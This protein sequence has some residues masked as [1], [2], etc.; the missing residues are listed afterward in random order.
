MLRCFTRRA[1]V[2]T[3]ATVAAVLG[4]AVA[5]IPAPALAGNV[6][7]NLTAT[8]GYADLDSTYQITNAIPIEGRLGLTFYR[9]ICV[10]G[11]YGKLF[12]DSALDP[13]RDFPAD[14]IGADVLL[15]ILP[16]ATFNPFVL[17]G[18]TQLSVD[19][20]SSNV[21]MNGFEFGGGIKIALMRQQ[22]TRLDMRLEARDVVVKNKSPFLPDGESTHNLF[23]TGAIELSFFGQEVDSDRDGVDNNHDDC[24]NTPRW[25]TVD[26]RGCPIDTD[27]D[28]VYDGIDQCPNTPHHA[29]VDD[30]G[31]PSDTDGDGV[32]D[33]IDRCPNTKQ[34]VKVD[35]TG[36]PLDSDGDGVG[37]G[38]DNCPNTPK[39]AIV[40]AAGCPIDNDRDGVYDGIDRCPNTPWGVE[41]DS[42]GCPVP[43]TEMEEELIDTGVLTLQ[44]IYFDIGKATIKPGSYPV[45]DEVAKILIRWPSLKI[46]IAGYTD[47]TGPEEFNQKLSQERAQSVLEYL[48]QNFPDLQFEQFLAMGYGESNPIASNDTV[49]G[50]TL[51]RRVQFK[52]L[53][54]IKIQ[55]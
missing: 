45:L 30:K 21:D 52:V 47:S 43:V 6:E 29:V 53:N 37:D 39:G 25:A 49:E 36:C 38:L 10:E 17:G 7:L 48:L 15:N 54:P 23:F 27:G 20:D 8:A 14:H 28:G 42:L 19:T 35:S 34:G 22:G 33:G 11:T 32:L 55:K 41:V 4:I 50:R 46:E 12:A 16:S 13:K 2:N 1:T 44:S 40:D 9:Y 5:L 3:R 24:P 26:S 31:C 18:W 51:N